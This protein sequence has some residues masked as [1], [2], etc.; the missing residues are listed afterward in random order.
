MDVVKQ[1]RG[2]DV[3]GTISIDSKAGQGTTFTL[4]IPLTLAIMDG[5]EVSVGTVFTIP[6][7]NIRQSFKIQPSELI[8]DTPPA[9]SCSSAWASSIRWCL[10]GSVSDSH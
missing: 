9:V 4:K 7:H 10:C 3:G 6:I 5:M 2:K 1:E 8:Q